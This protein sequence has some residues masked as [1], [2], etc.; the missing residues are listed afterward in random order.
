M[1]KRRTI[2]P[3]A[4]EVKNLIGNSDNPIMVLNEI[5]ANVMMT[6]TNLLEKLLDPRRDIET[7]CGWPDPK[8]VTPQLYADLYDSHPIANR[9]V[10]I[11]PK[12]CWK[13]YPEVYED[14]DNEVETEF[15][16]AWKELCQDMKDDSAYKNDKYNPI[17][18]VL[19]RAD[20]MSGIG[21]FGL[22]LLGFNDGR[23]FRYPLPGFEDPEEPNTKAEGDSSEDYKLPGAGTDDQYY[24]YG[25]YGT[26]LPE[27]EKLK[28]LYAKVFDES[29]IDISV[30][31]N[32]RSSKRYGLPVMYRVTLTD[33]DEQATGIG[34]PN[35]TVDVHWSR[36]LH[37]ADNV[38]GN[39]SIGVPR[40]RPVLRP[41]AD[42]KKVYG[43]SA[44]GYWQV[45]LPGV[46]LESEPGT[47]IDVEATK[48]HAQNYIHRLQRWLS[49][50]GM[51]AKTLQGTASDPT[52]Q[53][54]AQID[55]ICI[56]IGVPKRIFV[57]SERGEL[58]S[59]QDKDSWEE[60]LE[61]RR[62][63]YVIPK[64][65]APLIDRLIKIGV[66]PKPKSFNVVWNS[67]ENIS[68]LTKMQIAGAA[69]EALSK[70]IA[71]GVDA[72]IEP[73]DFLV[74]IMGMDQKKVDEFLKNTVK[75]LAKANP[76]AEQEI[77]PGRNPTPPELNPQETPPPGEEKVPEQK[78]KPK[79]NPKAV[80]QPPKKGAK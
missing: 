70:Y 8:S 7:E 67:A 6:R 80:K 50:S 48:Q 56:Q 9:V 37:I 39:E 47:E 12:E 57:G 22:V 35:S 61:E 59:T 21:H 53:I 72:L 78:A 33:L 15:E 73:T 10:N 19:S 69:T 52:S 20:V 34:Q 71:G 55:A 36:V 54:E 66:L 43:G 44:E 17:W 13:T 31:E 4:A 76:D 14:E 58:A 41:L 38:Q 16:K 32:R 63:M 3:N 42:L 24:D 79:L 46:V 11:F 60:R 64:I 28:L 26:E 51:T 2:D 77:V 27:G 49:L 74:E 1:A 62:S 23:D 18:E 68:K 29:L 65:I 75:H 5:V 45:C 40:M 30:W 25:N